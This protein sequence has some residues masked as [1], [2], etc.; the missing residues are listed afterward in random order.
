MIRDSNQ[1]CV[2]MSNNQEDHELQTQSL[3]IPANR[4]KQFCFTPSMDFNLLRQTITLDPFDSVYGDTMQTWKSI[5]TSL[6]KKYCF[7]ISGRK[8]RDHIRKLHNDWV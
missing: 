5:A 6:N 8:C 1:S 4:K 3:S 2:N 7:N